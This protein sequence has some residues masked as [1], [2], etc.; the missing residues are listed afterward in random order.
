MT[1]Y[2]DNAYDVTNFFVV[3]KKSWPILNSYKV[4]LFIRYQMAELSSGGG[5]GGCPSPSIIGVS[6]TPSKIGFKIFRERYGRSNVNPLKVLDSYESS[7]QLLISDG[8]A[9]VIE[10]AI[11]FFGMENTNDYPQYNNFVDNISHK[12]KVVKKE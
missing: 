1:S 4:S 8:K 11:E 2:S 12:S 10:A 3:F 5:G 9:Y 7:E 6:R